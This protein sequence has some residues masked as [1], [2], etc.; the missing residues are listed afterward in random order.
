MKYGNCGELSE[1]RFDER[2]AEWM[3]HCM[4]I[5]AMQCDA[6]YTNDEKRK[7]FKIQQVK[8]TRTT[9]VCYEGV[10]V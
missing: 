3:F 6:N 5:Y 9:A 1:R 8:V 2:T 7:S 10:R 4:N